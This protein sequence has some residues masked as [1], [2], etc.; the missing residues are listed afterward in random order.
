LGKI[1]EAE[2]ST[3]FTTKQ[4]IKFLLRYPMPKEKDLNLRP[5]SSAH[6]IGTTTLSLQ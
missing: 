3:N 2:G 4:D 5:P 6:V 1:S